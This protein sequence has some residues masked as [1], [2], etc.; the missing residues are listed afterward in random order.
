MTLKARHPGHEVKAITND[1]PQ[2]L[3]IKEVKE[4]TQRGLKQGRE[5]R[6]LS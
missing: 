4:K 1:P 2:P 5:E 6:D 3:T